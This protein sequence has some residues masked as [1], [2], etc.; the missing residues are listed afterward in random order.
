M[1]ATLIISTVLLLL[2]PVIAYP[3]CSSDFQCGA[4]NKCVKAPLQSQG[5]CMKAVNKYGVRTFDT[6][7]LDSVGPNMKI[8]G[9]CRF[10]TECPVGF[11][12]HPK[13]KACVKR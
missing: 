9:D 8:S 11:R 6:P 5:R 4:G 10:D 2:S 1:R 3:G 7:S 12:C 13:Y